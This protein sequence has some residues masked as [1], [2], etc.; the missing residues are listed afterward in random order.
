M[1]LSDLDM[2]CV[3]GW[4]FLMESGSWA[5]ARARGHFLR[6]PWPFVELRYMKGRLKS[7]E[8]TVHRAV[9]LNQGH[10]W[11]ILESFG[12]VT[13]ERSEVLPVSGG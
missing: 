4:N 13:I 10:V 8:M 12:V 5:A 11:Q 6:C 2:G 3:C 9:V 1:L 7:S